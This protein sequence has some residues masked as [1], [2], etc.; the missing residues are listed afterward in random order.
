LSPRELCRLLLL[1]AVITITWL[2]LTPR[3]PLAD[4]G[5]DKIN[6]LLAFTALSITAWFG[7]PGARRVAMATLLAYGGL[8]ELA[9]SFTPSRSA[10]W[11]DVAA[12]AVGIALGSLLAGGAELIRGRQR[13]RER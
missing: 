13:R 11:G 10:E 1:A 4:T 8:I 12:D 5:A 7:F 3:P 2:A 9:Q 6:H